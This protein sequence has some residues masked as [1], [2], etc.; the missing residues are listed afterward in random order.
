MTFIY[1]LDLYCRKI[2]RMCKYELRTLRLSKAIVGQT[3][4]YIYVQTDG[5]VTPGNFRSCVKDG[6]HTIRSVI[7]KN[8]MLNA[9]LVALSFIEPEL[10]AIRV[11]IAGIG[12]FD[13]FGSCD[14]TLTR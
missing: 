5:Q 8:P 10:W 4:R 7:V 9:N 12:I 11:Y 13:I 1:E 2:H 3:Y 6:G 14:L